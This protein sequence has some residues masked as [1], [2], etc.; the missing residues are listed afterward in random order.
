MSRSLIKQIT[1]AYDYQSS[2]D[3]LRNQPF[4]MPFRLGKSDAGIYDGALLSGD[5]E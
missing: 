3:S 4:Q 2:I 1:K 5:N